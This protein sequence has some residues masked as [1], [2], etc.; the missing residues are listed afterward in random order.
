MGATGYS[1]PTKQPSAYSA[2]GAGARC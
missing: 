2:F 1:W